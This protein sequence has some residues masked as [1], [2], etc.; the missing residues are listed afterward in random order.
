MVNYDDKRNFYRM[1]VNSEVT[2]TI[3][4]DEAN[5]KILA[6][7]RDLSATGIAIEMEHPLEM[8]TAVHVSVQSANSAVQPLDVKGKVV[9][10]TE[11]SA[12]CFLIGVN[13]SEID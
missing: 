9:R 1:M 4:D 2:V 12:N 3:I 10:V 6:T 7:C 13:I 8:N 11:E 5:S